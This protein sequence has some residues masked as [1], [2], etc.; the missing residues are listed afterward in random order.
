MKP[1]SGISVIL[2][3]V[4]VVLVLPVVTNVA[5]NV[6][7]AFFDPYLWLVW[8]LAV[9][10][11]IPVVITEVRRNRSH[12]SSKPSTPSAERVLQQAVTDQRGSVYQAGRDLILTG[13]QSQPGGQGTTSGASPRRPDA[14]IGRADVDH[15]QLFG[16]ENILDRLG[17]LLANENG[18][19]IISIFG[20]GGAGK[21]TLA[22][23]MVRRH[24]EQAGFQRIAWVSAKF[25]HLGALGSVQ[26]THA[27]IDW[28]DML[29]DATRQMELEIDLNPARIEYHLASALH[30]MNSGDHCLIVI[31]NLETIADAERAVNFLDGSDVLRPHKVVITTRKSTERLSPLV[32]EVSWYGLI[33]ADARKF[34]RYLAADAP[35]FELTTS[36]LDDVVATSGGIPLLIKMI[37]RLAIVEATSV[38]EVTAR[39]RDPKGELGERIGIYLYEQAMNALAAKVGQKAAISLMNVFCARASSESFTRAELHELSQIGDPGLFNRARAAARD[40]ALIRGLEGNNRFTVHP[41]LREFVCNSD[42]QQPS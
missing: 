4:I 6:L 11:A 33:P 24:A 26:Q 34:A 30:S 21:T 37:V 35:G 18:D 41:L 23:E 28:H 12:S 20:E 27:T 19:W 3:T 1:P 13:D 32:H 40:L 14:W 42:D 31:D 39:L 25:S 38:S 10:L 29:L 22:Y 15:D 2:I 5:A 16:V 9:L 8:P 17:R 7:P 36:D